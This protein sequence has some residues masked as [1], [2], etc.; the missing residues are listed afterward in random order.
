ML[1]DYALRISDAP[2]SLSDPD[3]KRIYYPRASFWTIKQGV[4]V[5][6]GEAVGLGWVA[7]GEGGG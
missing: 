4:G 1:K 5:D 3:S 6:A 2:P 7:G